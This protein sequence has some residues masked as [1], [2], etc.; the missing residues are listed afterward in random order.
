DSSR[1]GKYHGNE[2]DLE[3]IFEMPGPD[4]R[5]VSGHDGKKIFEVF[6]KFEPSLKSSRRRGRMCQGPFCYPMIR[7]KRSFKLP[8]QI[9]FVGLDM[10]SIEAARKADM[11]RSVFMGII[12]SLI[13]LSGLILLF[14]SHGY[15]SAKASLSMIRAFS[16]NLVENMPIGLIATDHEGRIASCNQV[17]ETLI[18][19]EYEQVIGEDGRDI[20]PQPLWE[21]FDQ[22]DEDASETEREVEC[23]LDNG[24]IVWFQITGSQLRDDQARFLG[25]VLL[26]KDLSEVRSLR[27]EIARSQ[28]LASIGSLAAGVAHEIRNPLSSIKGF[29]TYFKERYKKIEEDRKIADI[30]IQEVERL[31]RVVG[32]L[33]ELSRPVRIT[34]QKSCVIKLAENTLELIAKETEKRNIG[35][36]TDFTKEK[37]IVSVD[38]DQVSQVFLNLYINAIEAMEDSGTLSVRVSS[39]NDAKQ[40]RIQVSDTGPGIEKKDLAHVFDPYYTTKSTGTGLGL[41]I[42]HNIL[43]AHE[44]E[45]RMESLSGKGC[46]ATVMLPCMGS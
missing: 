16:N 28:R 15:R 33:L 30:M 7:G 12:L 25:Y 21:L 19:I 27:A 32:Q 40:I 39:A 43:E 46:T 34:K 10:S 2:L 9:I 1:T 23:R 45:V 6:G 4:W 18:D 42:V 5:M 17:A 13:G 11:N 20:L 31:D 14:I 8:A 37:C 24:K 3:S 22:M 36:K 29:A 44:G 41:A 26:F 38:A 35:I